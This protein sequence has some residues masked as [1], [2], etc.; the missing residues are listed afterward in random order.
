MLLREAMLYRGDASNVAEFEFERTDVAA[1]FGPGIY[2]TSDPEVAHDYTA[3]R[4]DERVYPQGGGAEPATS[5]RALLQGYVEWLASTFD[6]REYRDRWVRKHGLGERYS[7]LQSGTHRRMNDDMEEAKLLSKRERMP[8]ALAK[9]RAD[10]KHLRVARLTTGELVLVRNDR[11]SALSGFN[12]PDEYLARVLHAERPLPDKA[13]AALR[14]LWMAKYPQDNGDLRDGSNERIRGFD[15]FVATFKKRGAH[16]AWAE[17]GDPKIGGRGEN[18]SLDDL[19]N[20]THGGAH[21]YTDMLF[22]EGKPNSMN[23]I[24]T[25]MKLGY[26]GLEYDGGKRLGQYLRGGGGRAHRAYVLWDVKTVNG[27]RRE[28]LPLPTLKG[29]SA[30]SMPKPSPAG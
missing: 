5:V 2:L 13:L 29:V 23:L 26:V 24:R 12:I 6:E 20:G 22:T 7:G 28:N 17:D 14:E 9:T 16:R 27:F 15:A 21:V 8:E 25:L 19:R 30:R 10:L 11:T 1:L 18:P 3:A 4:S